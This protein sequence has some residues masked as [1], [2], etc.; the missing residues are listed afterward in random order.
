M[1]PHETTIPNT[2]KA[3][4]ADHDDKFLMKKEHKNIHE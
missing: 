4:A 1:K 3:A 2:A